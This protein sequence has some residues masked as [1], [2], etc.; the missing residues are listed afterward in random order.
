[1]R[2]LIPFFILLFFQP[3]YAQNM[4]DHYNRDWKKADS[5]LENGFPESAIKVINSIYIKAKQ[6][7]ATV[8]VIKAELFLLSANFERSEEAYETA[9]STTEGYIQ[10]SSFPVKN[11]WQSIA[12]QLYWNYYQQNRWKI[13]ERTSVSNETTI[14]DIDQ[15][16]A[17][18][19]FEK[20]SSLYQASLNNSSAL[21]KIDISNYE[22]ILIK[23]INTKQLRPTLYDLLAF[24]ALSY[25]SDEEKDLISPAFAFSLN[26][27]KLFDPTND[28]IQATFT[29]KDETAL[30]FQ[31]IQIYQQLLA[32]HSKDVKADALID[33]DLSRLDFAYQYATLSNK[34]EL[35]KNALDNIRQRYPSNPLSGLAAIRMVDLILEQDI[36]TPQPRGGNTTAFKKQDIIQAKALLDAVIQKFPNSEVGRQAQSLL[37]NLE[38]KTLNLTV[39]AIVLPNEPSKFLLQYKNVNQVSIK[40]VSITDKEPYWKKSNSYNN[41]EHEIAAILQLPVVNEWTVSLPD[42][43]DYNQHR[44]EI[45]IDKL[46][47]GMYAVI[48][49]ADNQFKNTQN[50]LAYSTFQVSNLSLVQHSHNNNGYILHRKTGSPQ[51]NVHVTFYKQTYNNKKHQ[52][53]YIQQGTIASNSDGSFTRAHNDY[54]SYVKL[55][56]KEDEVFINGN[57]NSYSDYVEDRAQE[58]SFIFT[59]RSIYRPGQT[60]YFKGIVFRKTNNSKSNDI[61]ANHPTTVTLLDANG[62]KVSSL[63]LTTNEF[64]SFSGKMV[65]P[66]GILTGN[67]SLTNESGSASIAVEEYK[68]PKFFVSFDTLKKTYALGDFVSSSGQATAYAGN[69]IDGA[70]VSYRVT[71]T[72]RFP[73]PWLCYYYRYIPQHEEME[74]ANGTT[75]TDAKGQF[76]INFDALADESV[77]P[78]SLPI[79]NFTITATITDINGETRS[80]SH[81]IHLGY[82]DM[83]L[84]VS[85]PEVLTKDNIS[86]IR[87]T[88]ESLNGVFLPSKA[89]IKITQLQEPA[90]V[91]RKRLWET[92]DVFIMDSVSFKKDFPNDVYKDEDDY[93]NWTAKHVVLDKNFTTNKNGEIAL[94]NLDWKEDGWYEIALTTKDSKG[95][96]ITE[97]KYTQV[98]NSYRTT[99]Q[100]L[101]IITDKTTVEPGTTASATLIS[102]YD[103]LHLIRMEKDMKGIQPITQLSYNSKPLLWSKAITEQDRGGVMITYLTVKEN[104]VY[105]EQAVITV[106]WTNKDLQI[107]WETH[108]DKLLP[109][110]AET[111]TMVIR[112]HKKEKIAAELVATLYDASL[113]ALKPHQWTKHSLFPLLNTYFY[114]NTQYGFQAQSGIAKNWIQEK[115]YKGI[116]KQYAEIDK[117]PGYNNYVVYELY[118]N[119]KAMSMSE[120]MPMAADAVAKK[121]EAAPPSPTRNESNQSSS[122]S[123]NNESTSSPEKNTDIPIRKN[124]QETAFFF[125]QLKTDAEG[126]IRLSF[127][128]PEALTEWKL[129]AFAH[130]KD[131]STGFLEGRIKTQKELMVVPNLPRFLRQGDYV[132]LSTKLVNLT[133]KAMTGKAKINIKNALTG[134]PL[135][136]PFRIASNEKTFSIAAQQSTSQAWDLHIPESIYVPV[137][138]TITATAGDFADGEENTLPVLTNRMLVT[139]TLPIWMN[140][141]GNKTY[142]FEKLLAADSS[143]S[144]SQHLLTVEYTANPAW[145]AV[146]A[147]PYMMEYPYECAEQTFNRFYATALAAFILEKAPKVKSIFEQWKKEGTS[148]SLISPLEKNQELKAALLQE[149]PW[150]F[151]AQ[152][153]TEQMQR[154]AQLFDSYKLAKERKATLKKLIEKQH[155]DGAFGWFDG[156]RADRYITQYIVT[157]LA[158]LKKMGVEDNDDM[159]E[160]II[161]KALPSLDQSIERDYQFLVSR[162]SPL[163]QLQISNLQIQYLYMRSFIQEAPLSIDKKIITYYS[164]QA[165]KYWHRFNGLSK[166]MIALSFY[167]QGNHEIP[168]TILQSLKETSIYKEEMGRYWATQGNSYWWYDAPIETQSLLISCFHEINGDNEV[169]DELKRWLLKNKQTNRWESTKATADACYALLTTGNNWLEAAPQVSIKLGDKQISSQNNKTLE[170]SG[171]FKT[172]WYGKDIQPSM[173]NIDIQLSNNTA[174]KTNAPSWGAVYWQYFEDMDKLSSAKTSLIINKQFFIEKNTARGPELTAITEKNGLQIGDKVM[175]RLTLTTDRAMEYV[176]LKDM[177]A[178]CFEPVNVLSGY[179]YQNG[180]GYYES[181]KDISTNFFFDHLPKGTYVLEYP[182]YVQQ[183]GSFSSGIA[184]L[185]CMYAPEFS[186]HSEGIKV[187]VR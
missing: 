137:T 53:D 92:P 89:T 23:S 152:S 47:I 119:V 138:I 153:E 134:Q 185:Q 50:L 12:A 106:P 178:A 62:Q 155:P 149:T 186:S 132:T 30:Q 75:I 182:V 31:A 49:S 3:T 157:G 115:Y 175:V 170:G 64:G 183:K 68:R 103:K 111:W 10:Q 35:Y 109:G 44:T 147:L 163:D 28:F 6:Q 97:K 56:S 78:N 129:M 173:G 99:S 43:I 37:Q 141:I 48:V 161:N 80:N 40:V 142:R 65:A 46:P 114:W 29:T 11:I 128:M 169:V 145:Y 34:K 2:Y 91:L 57:F 107:S 133:T 13:L 20:V 166:G 167:R 90:T 1:M 87:A 158:K 9:I 172:S 171:Y 19:F 131:M 18:R 174:T 124:L 60:I 112:G 5:L 120:G 52:Y 100:A 110:A 83:V 4:N 71:R 39:E 73:Y 113:D 42:T 168:K 7:G 88:T 121:G 187:T 102:G 8:Q 98:L 127:T 95:K 61:L 93:R 72:Y 116:P 21:A 77:A 27:A 184:S 108:R 70:T 160:T 130:S 26:D 144:I 69:A 148:S 17:K 45:K 85:T 79:F 135:D 136:L 162:K 143:K 76:N 82:S 15:W 139:E 67:M 33:A 59:D 14:A 94:P 54:L 24:R 36:A 117:I 63:N 22:P 81:T 25:F 140:G 164:Q 118:E 122:A 66:D 84:T 58:Q 181:T 125:P 150:V 38:R 105:T 159:M 96:T 151:E 165:G 16:D 180:L 86:S 55:S 176:H 32:I 146:Q 177:R 74:I 51:A 123:N 126:N 156:M 179:K 101:A 154:I 104:R 41:H